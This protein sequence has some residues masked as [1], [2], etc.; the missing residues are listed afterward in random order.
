MKSQSKFSQ[1]WQNSLLSKLK[2]FRIP[3]K[4]VFVILGI[5]SMA[6]FLIRVIPKPQR[7]TYPCMK[8]TAP[9]A[10]SFIIYLLGISGG[11]VYFRR[12]LKS[13]RTMKLIPALGFL[14]LALVLAF[15]GISFNKNSVAA[16]EKVAN[17][18][19][20]NNPMGVAKGINPGRV[21]WVY[22]P[23]AT[24]ESIQNK[25]KSDHSDSYFSDENTNQAIVD[26]MVEE[27]VLK[28]TDKSS[29]ADAWTSI[30]K[31]HNNQRGKGE[32]GYAAGEI[33][34]IKINA[35]STWGGNYD[36]GNLSRE[37]NNNYAISETSPQVVTAVL[38]QLVNVVGVAQS[39][40]YLGDP[41]KHIYKDLY[42][43]WSG[44]FPDVHYLDNSTQ[45][46]GIGREG[47][48]KSNSAV[49]DYSD[50]GEVLREG[51]WSSALTGDPIDSDKLYTIF[52]DMEYMINLPTLKGHKHAGVTMFAKN[53]FGS[54]TR[55]DAKHLHGGLV[56]MGNDPTRNEYGMYR[57]LVDLLGHELLGKKNLIYLLDA[58]YCSEMEVNQP[59]KF[60]KE[61][62]N[63]DWTSSI[64]ISQDP[65]AI[66]S[67]G[68][69][70]LYYELDGSNGLDDF[71]HY[72]AV[73][74]YLHQAA[75]SDNW[76]VGISYDPENDGTPIESLG[77]H[78]HWNNSTDMQ[79]SRNLASGEGIELLKVDGVAVGVELLE[80]SKSSAKVFPNP[81]F[82]NVNL[83]IKGEQR[84][85]IKVSIIDVKG[86]V[87]YSDSFFKQA[88]I[89]NKELNLNKLNKG[90]Y[91]VSYGDSENSIKLIKR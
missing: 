60:Q 54:Q 52:E 3:T 67:V 66:E 90:I 68:F 19:D 56:K 6:W 62:W 58:L 44:E 1:N 69:D 57:V 36:S 75:S 18:D 82:G 46:S 81:T 78:E 2:S 73:D 88:E 65:I 22:E 50:R 79:Y 20:P 76:P 35:T 53:H 77:V 14:V 28:M 11:L 41:M 32:V 26:K 24:N 63:N 40:I 39:D 64:F 51:D 89:L 16:V 13:A 85:S 55:V 25:Y 34:F 9:I 7:A 43:K 31:Y 33:V 87:V 72:G 91:F 84:G 10:S 74:D 37:N 83:E 21:V 27:A 59:D 4:V 47:V 49:V 15:T 29:M 12:F 23:D 48:A 42:D 70:M 45:Y 61:P 5:V 38:R 80:L 8:A 30:F 71:P 17:P 86:Q